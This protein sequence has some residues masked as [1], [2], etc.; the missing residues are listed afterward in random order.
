VEGEISHWHDPTPR[1]R[2][3]GPQMV[4][5]VILR[6]PYDF[7]SN[8]DKQTFSETSRLSSTAD[9]PAPAGARCA[10]S[11]LGGDG[12]DEVSGAGARPDVLS[13]KSGVTQ[14]PPQVQEKEP[15]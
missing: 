15:R 1:R 8:P 4:N 12:G 14:P 2:R 7:R 9:E 6:Y 10:R 3:D 5:H 13:E 11:R